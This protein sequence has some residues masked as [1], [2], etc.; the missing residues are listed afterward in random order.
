MASAERRHVFITRSRSD[1]Q[2]ERVLDVLRDRFSVADSILLASDLQ[3]PLATR[4]AMA[5]ASVVVVVLPPPRNR[6]RLNVIFDAGI[7][8]GQALPV[9]IVSPEPKLPRGLLGLPLVEATALNKLPAVVTNA[10]KSGKTVYSQ[11]PPRK[12]EY[13]SGGAISADSRPHESS[14]GRNLMSEAQVLNLLQ[15]TLKKEGIKVL[16]PEPLLAESPTDR[17]DLVVWDDNLQHMF[18]LPLPVE[19]I[20]DTRLSKNLRSRLRH[21]LHASGA[22]SLI[23]VGVGGESSFRWADSHELILAVPADDLL[24][25]TRRMPFHRA[26]ASLQET[27]HIA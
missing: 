1:P 4:T 6:D 5:E 16:R 22:R 26:L 21:T 12:H 9:V 15:A 17:A 18:G 25:L 14:Q 27:A 20:R 19:V 11:R 23:A 2:S 3:P 7:A 13:T 24:Q 8:V 10:A